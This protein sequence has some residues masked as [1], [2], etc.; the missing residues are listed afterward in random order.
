M[1]LL[2]LLPIVYATAI[3]ETSLAD[4]IR[5]GHV[6]PDLLAMVAMIWLLLVPGPRAFVGAG[7]IGLASDLIAPGR[8]G[9]AMACFLLVGYAAGRL[10]ARL[11]PDHLVSRVLA[12][13]LGVTAL[14]VSLAIGR[15]LLGEAPVALSTLLLRALGVGI[16]TAGVSLPFLMVIGWI[17]EPFRTPAPRCTF[18]HTSRTT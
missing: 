14:A 6:A 12:V 1:R 8:V 5:V 13:W 17:Q 10:R 2:F 4:V 15:W 16:Y 7:A 11:Q 9:L 18:F 3:I